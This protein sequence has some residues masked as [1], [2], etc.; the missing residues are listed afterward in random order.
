[1]TLG[2]RLRE[3]SESQVSTMT[4]TF[5]QAHGSENLR[6]FETI[7]KG[8]GRGGRTEIT[9]TYSA[10]GNEGKKSTTSRLTETYVKDH[11]KKAGDRKTDPMT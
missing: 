7:V 10:K 9:R 3:Y 8:G 4:Q 2:L 1:L 5:D 11:A 6:E